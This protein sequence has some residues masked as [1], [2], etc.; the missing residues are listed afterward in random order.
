MRLDPGNLIEAA[1]IVFFVYWFVAGL[2]VKKMA[3]NEPRAQLWTRIIVMLAAFYLILDDDARF[4]VLNRRFVPATQAFF[5]AGAGLTVL[6]LGFAIWARYHLGKYWSGTVA[7]REG[8]ELIRSGPYSRIRHPIYTGMLVAVFGGAL[9]VGRYRALAGFV[10]VLLGF[11]WK[12]RR[13]EHLLAGAFGD[14]FK[15]H[16]RQTGFFLP[17][18]LSVPRT[19]P[20]TD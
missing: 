20:N 14:K 17:R 4:G 11:V 16:R 12:S 1:W 15:E 18:F 8:H 3:R 9:A 19:L 2:S 5:D 6:G 13:E 7:L 10:L